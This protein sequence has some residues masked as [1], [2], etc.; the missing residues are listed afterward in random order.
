MN[1]MVPAHFSKPRSEA[2]LRG[3][4]DRYHAELSKLAINRSVLTSWFT[5]EQHRSRACLRVSASMLWESRNQ[6]TKIAAIDSARSIGTWPP[7]SVSITSRCNRSI[8]GSTL[9]SPAVSL[10]TAH[11]L[12]H[13]SFP[14]TFGRLTS[15]C[16]KLGLESLSLGRC[17]RACS[18]IELKQLRPTPA[19][20]PVLSATEL[21]DFT[22]FEATT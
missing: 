8:F 17:S 15:R 16:P 18:H 19:R 4:A 20:G 7:T 9:A 22:P 21:R 2:S 5:F 14:A 12:P 1:A 10:S 13:R 3:V 11:G 6:R